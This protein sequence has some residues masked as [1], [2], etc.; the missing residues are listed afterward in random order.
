MS[1]SQLCLCVLDWWHGVSPGLGFVKPLYP[2][3]LLQVDKVEA[4]K[5]SQSTRDCLHAKYN[6]HTC[7]TVVG[8]HEWGHLQLDA[9]SLYLLMLAQMT[10]SGGMPFGDLYLEGLRH[11]TWRGLRCFGALCTDLWLCS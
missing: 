5:Y 6:T 4:F 3:P 8:D 9:T 1:C 7:A 10:A 11:V 2:F